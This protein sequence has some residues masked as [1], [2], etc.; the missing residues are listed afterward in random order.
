MR[1]KLLVNIPVDPEHGMTASRELEV[2]RLADGKERGT[3]GVWVAGD[4][5]IEVR[6]MRREYEIMED[7]NG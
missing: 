6:L 4:A 7:D 2:L 5:G 1:V 3:S